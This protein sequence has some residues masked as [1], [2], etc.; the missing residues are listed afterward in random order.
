MKKVGIITMLGNY[1]CGN[2]LQN[3]A[4]QEIIK[5]Q[6][7]DVYTIKNDRFLNNKEKFIKNFLKYIRQEIR[8]FG[9][10]KKFK[11][12]N[13]NIKFSK[14][15]LTI[16][17]YKKYDKMY[18]YFVVG[19]DQIWKPTR[20]RMSFID[21]LGFASPNK[22]IAYAPSFGLEKIDSKY[23][24]LLQDELP[25]FKKISVREYAGKNII[26]DATGID[27]VEVLLDPTMMLDL[28]QWESFEQKPNVLKDD[29]YIFTYFLGNEDINK[30]KFQFGK[31]Y[32]QII[33]FYN[34]D[35]GPQE[36]LYLIHHAKL[37]LTDSFH[38]CAFSILFNKDFYIFERKEVS[39]NNNMNSRID[40]LSRKFNLES[41]RID[42]IEKVNIKDS[43]DYKV[44]NALLERER[45][46]SKEFLKNAFKEEG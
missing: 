30:I 37:I 24:K 43:I 16:K 9:K 15:F 36:F 35:F 39:K 41:R 42:S 12:F 19:S 45:K 1:N 8:E 10:G 13:K 7:F 17:N 29:N 25:K 44:I 33:D 3:Y 27:D 32:Y 14:H 2:R 20:L 38:A 22:R 34:Y 31:E 46:S 23:Y 21:L 28:K 18:D 4:L 5:E 11:E 6:G 40:T 26:K